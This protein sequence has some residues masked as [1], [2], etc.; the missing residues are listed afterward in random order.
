MVVSWFKMFKGDSIRIRIRETCSR[1]WCS[2][3]ANAGQGKTIK[4]YICNGVG[5]IA[6]NYTQSKR[7]QNFDY[8]KDKMLLMQAQ[9]NGA[10]LDEEELL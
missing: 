2:R 5:H 9:E 3:N 8:F 1:K 10:V 4:C 6:R 7:P